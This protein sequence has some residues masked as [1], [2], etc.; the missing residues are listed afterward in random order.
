M[1]DRHHTAGGVVGPILF[2]AAFVVEG[3]T[4]TVCLI[5][6]EKSPRLL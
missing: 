3:A 1:P 6:K 2:V 5:D 4:V